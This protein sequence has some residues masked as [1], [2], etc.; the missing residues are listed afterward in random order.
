MSTGERAHILKSP[1]SS[2]TQRTDTASSST[3]RTGT[4]AAMKAGAIDSPVGPTIEGQSAVRKS[5]DLNDRDPKH[6]KVRRDGTVMNDDEIARLVEA[7]VYSKFGVYKSFPSSARD[8]VSMTTAIAPCEEF[9]T[10]FRELSGVI[11]PSWVDPKDKINYDIKN[12][13]MLRDLWENWRID[14]FKFC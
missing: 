1:A 8:H 9:G 2:S 6:H 11:P 10:L 7:K 3:Q 14:A 4:A 5:I 12:P 13:A